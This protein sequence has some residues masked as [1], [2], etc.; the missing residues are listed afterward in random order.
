VFEVGQGAV[1]GVGE[2]AGALGGVKQR[3]MGGHRYGEAL[4]LRWP[5][6]TTGRRP[7]GAGPRR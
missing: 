3:A 7:A 6:R 2:S 4:D 1:R 5:A